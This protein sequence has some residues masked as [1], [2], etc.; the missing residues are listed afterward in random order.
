MN[1]EPMNT[2]KITPPML[3]TDEWQS[4]IAADATP[5][6]H[7]NGSS[8]SDL[9]DEWENFDTALKNALELFPY[10]SFAPRNHYVRGE[11]AVAHAAAA[12]HAMVYILHKMSEIPLA[13]IV[14]MEDQ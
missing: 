9:L 5:S 8:K 6:I 13:V 14:N 2:M 1:T 3:M 12:K 7:L 4:E 11:E 10:E